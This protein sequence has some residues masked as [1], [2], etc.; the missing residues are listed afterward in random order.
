M[1][2]PITRASI[3][4]VTP[5]IVAIRAPASLAALR[6]AVWES[7]WTVG[8]ITTSAASIAA[9][10]VAGGSAAWESRSAITASVASAPSPWAT[11]RI[12]SPSP[13][14][15]GLQTTSTSSP[16]ADRQAVPDHR[17]DRPVQFLG[18][19]PR[20]LPRPAAGTTPPLPFPSPPE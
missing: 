17:L 4:S 11:I 7:D 10:T 6:A 9:A 8:A 12:R 5:G 16:G 14:V 19:G 15:T 18:H 20:L 3:S 2:A 1:S 13:S